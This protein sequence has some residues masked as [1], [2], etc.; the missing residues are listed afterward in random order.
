MDKIFITE[1]RN[2]VSIDQ[3]GNV[4]EVNHKFVLIDWATVL[5]KDCTIEYKQNNETK[6]ID[7]TAGQLVLVYYKNSKNMVVVV[8]NQ[9]MIE[10][11]EGNS[12]NSY[13]PMLEDAKTA[14]QG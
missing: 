3:D 9:Q 14:T 5:E 6:S 4:S 1:N 10:N 8:D 13:N 2:A 12:V 11:F 7:G